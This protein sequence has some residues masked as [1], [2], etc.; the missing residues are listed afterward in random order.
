[1]KETANAIQEFINF[2][3]VYWYF[4]FIYIW[5]IATTIL[6]FREKKPWKQE[7][8]SFNWIAYLV[9]VGA[10]FGLFYGNI[11]AFK[12]FF[13]GLV[14]AFAPP[15]MFV[16]EIIGVVME[17]ILPK[18]GQPVLVQIVL[19]LICCVAFIFLIYVLVILLA[20]FAVLGAL[21][22]V[23]WLLDDLIKKWFSWFKFKFQYSIPLL[24]LIFYPAADFTFNFLAESL[25]R[26]PLEGT[27]TVKASRTTWILII[28]SLILLTGI[29][30]KIFG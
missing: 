30:G 29:L 8:L 25:T 19:F 22:V 11:V 18:S 17:G 28:G 9:V 24:S 13:E 1:M 7:E 3:K 21:Y 23:W 15:I 14:I 2:F 20:L 5:L 16:I 27:L 12:A 6:Y 26:H 4:S 10:L